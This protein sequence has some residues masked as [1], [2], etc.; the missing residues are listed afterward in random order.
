LI[1]GYGSPTHS[2][3]P[4]SETT[5]DS[6]LL[7]CLRHY[8]IAAMGRII[9]HRFSSLLARFLSLPGTLIYLTIELVLSLLLAGLTTTSPLALLKHFDAYTKVCSAGAYRLLIIDGHESHC[10]VEFQDYC[11][12]NKIIALCM[13]PHLSHLLQ[14]RD[15]A[16]YS[17]LKH[18]YGN[19]ISLLARSCIHHIN[20]DTFLPAFRA[21][22][23]KTFTAENTCAGL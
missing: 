12:E 16:F 21:V 5:P 9:S 13:P 8:S 1:L 17:L 2:H 3:M 14:P 4:L 23:E 18:Y 22:F 20:N 11:K 10:S 19:K 6:D 15:V 7:S